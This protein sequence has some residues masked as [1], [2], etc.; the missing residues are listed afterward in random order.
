MFRVLPSLSWLLSGLAV[1]TA[2]VV[3][4]TTAQ[5]LS[6]GQSTFDSNGPAPNFA[7]FTSASDKKI[8]FFGYLLPLIKQSNQAVVKQ[9]ARLEKIAKK[10]AKDPLKEEDAVFLNQLANEYGYEY[11][12]PGD[13]NPQQK[14][15]FLRSRVNRLPES[16]VLA[17]AVKESG[18]GTSNHAR[19]ANN[20]F[21]LRCH[22]AGC[23]L[24]PENRSGDAD[25]EIRQFD[26]AAES[27]NAFLKHI[28]TDS[29]YSRLRDIRA[30]PGK[31]GQASGLM[32]AEGLSRN[33]QRERKYRKA[34]QSIIRF[35]E[36]ESL[37]ES[38]K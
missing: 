38:I 27:V 13:A 17:I 20:Y 29:T 33:S 2:T 31:Q 4:W 30:E 10:A 7:A 15:N 14:I 35:N 1:L 32:L 9:R 36:L 37:D 16:L 22:E 19:D 11:E 5:H 25:H 24:I 34:I 28:N 8:A 12:T 26:H 18:W 3:V 21:N 23:G 6:Q